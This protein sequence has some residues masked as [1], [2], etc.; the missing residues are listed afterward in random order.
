M[1][2]LPKEATYYSDPNLINEAIVNAKKSVFRLEL[3]PEYDVQYEYESFK[4]FIDSGAVDESYVDDWCEVIQKVTS[5][6]VDCTRVRLVP[7]DLNDYLKYE[8]A[9]Y[10][11]SFEAGENIRIISNNSFL[12]LQENNLIA[13]DYWLFDEEKCFVMIYDIVG[14]FYGFIE[15]NNLKSLN[16]FIES[17]KLYIQNSVP[18]QET[19]YW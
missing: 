10:R 18:L 8:I 11:F 14:R 3:L 12:V 1:L 6:G 4:K 9:V 2:L 19:K 7:D 16:W 13:I 15:V 17:S 5:K